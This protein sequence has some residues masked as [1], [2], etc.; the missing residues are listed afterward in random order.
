MAK[1]IASS[2]NG[3]VRVSVDDARLLIQ[4]LVVTGVPHD[5]VQ[6]RVRRGEAAEGVVR[7]MIDLGA[8]L[9]QHGAN[10][11]TVDSV[12][13]Q[14]DRLLEVVTQVAS[15][16]LPQAIDA[17]I[18]V[19]R[20]VLSAHLDP[21]RADSVQRQL[22]EVF[23]KAAEDNQRQMRSALLDETGPLGIVR[24]ELGGQLRAIAVQQGTLAEQVTQLRE[25]LAAADGARREHQRGTAHGVEFEAL[26]GVVVE[27]AHAPYH[28]TVVDVGCELG[29]SRNKAGDHVVTVDPAAT[30]AKDVRVVLEAKARPLGV[31][32]AL[33][34]LDRAMANR[35]AQSGVLVFAGTDLAPLSG[36][37]MRVFSGN[38][39]MAVLQR[40]DPDPL[41]VEV[42][43]HLARTLAL[44]TARNQEQEL[45]CDLL[46]Q[47]LDCLVEIVED[48]KCI[49][50]GAVA[51]RK[52]I[53][54]VE[55]GYDALRANALAVIERISSSLR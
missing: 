55:V 29:A 18:G 45:D 14:I 9:A 50:R 40:E 28:D 23:S 31:R 36:R 51:A 4:H 12:K 30:D 1:T 52:G 48:G 49:R 32:E 46:R 20:E 43:C 27:H 8:G 2:T 17:R 35:E 42:S 10:Q 24:S 7:Q 13:V 21:K 6:A 38:R 11:A 44:L 33:R 54:A 53:D 47:E 3:S 5:V 19:M 34:E 41:A 37:A 22:R 26:V 16:Q 39:I 25:Q 15:N